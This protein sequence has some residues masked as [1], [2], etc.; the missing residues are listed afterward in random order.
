MKYSFDLIDITRKGLVE[1]PP[2]TPEEEKPI[3]TGMAIGSA[4]KKQVEKDVSG[5][6]YTFMSGENENHGTYFT[7]DRSIIIETKH[8]PRG[9]YFELDLTKTPESHLVYRNLCNLAENYGGVEI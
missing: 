3:Y 8:A 4:I 6:E 1:I 9:I 2:Y 5:I 7:K